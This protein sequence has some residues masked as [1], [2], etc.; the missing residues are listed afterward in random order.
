MDKMKLSFGITDDLKF[1]YGPVHFEFESWD[2]L[3]NVVDK[4]IDGLKCKSKCRE[5]CEGCCGDPSGYFVAEY[6]KAY[7]SDIIAGLI[8]NKYW[9]W[10]R[11]EKY[12]VIAFAIDYTRFE[13]FSRDCSK[14]VIEWGE[15]EG[16]LKGIITNENY[17]E[18]PII[19]LLRKLNN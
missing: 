3:A 14:K 13:I 6:Y 8:E 1:A 12:Y 17:N 10:N 16:P 11:F 9:V 19:T 15:G 4:V 2:Q 5:W 7:R 18:N